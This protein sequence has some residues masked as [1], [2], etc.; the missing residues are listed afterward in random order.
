M[1]IGATGYLRR[2]A[3]LVNWGGPKNIARAFMEA[4]LR[5]GLDDTVE[6]IRG[7]WVKALMR[8]IRRTLGAYK[9]KIKGRA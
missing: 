5:A 9:P 6:A 3:H 1:R 8:Q 4:A 2:F 7:A